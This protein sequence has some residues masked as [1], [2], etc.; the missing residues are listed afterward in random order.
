MQKL[1]SQCRRKEGGEEGRKDK[2]LKQSFLPVWT[3]YN[4]GGSKKRTRDR[5]VNRTTAPASVQERV[6]EGVSLC[7][8]VIPANIHTVAGGKS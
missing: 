6:L 5:K 1:I 7:H 2:S 8:A 3:A 4:L